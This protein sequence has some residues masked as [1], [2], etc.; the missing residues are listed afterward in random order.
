MTIN[1]TALGQWSL[2]SGE[3]RLIAGAFHRALTH[4]SSEGLPLPSDEYLD[5][6]LRERGCPEP[7]WRIGAI[8]SGPCASPIS[9]K[10]LRY[11]E[12]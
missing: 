9:S 3:L 4:A 11:R 6:Q 2:P 10:A 8:A 1:G 12:Q 5:A 7:N